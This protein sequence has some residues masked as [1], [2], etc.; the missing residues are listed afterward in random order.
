M[1]L[2]TRAY[3]SSEMRKTEKRNTHIRVH[4]GQALT[5]TSSW[6]LWQFTVVVRQLT[7]KDDFMVSLCLLVDVYL[8]VLSEA[9]ITKGIICILRAQIKCWL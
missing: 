5:L 8:L 4:D 2:K 1:R 3:V 6:C 7:I 9:F